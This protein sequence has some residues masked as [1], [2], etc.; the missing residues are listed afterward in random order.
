MDVTDVTP[1]FRLF[2]DVT[3]DDEPPS[4]PYLRHLRV[5]FF[6]WG[7]GLLALGGYGLPLDFPSS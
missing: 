6:F 1:W 7:G 3:N 5:G 4:S 2:M